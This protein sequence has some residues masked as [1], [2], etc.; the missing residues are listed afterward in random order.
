MNELI[1]GAASGLLVASVFVF[2]FV[3]IMFAVVRDP[4]LGFQQLARRL[5]PGTLVLSGVLMAYPSWAVIGAVAG[6]LYKIS[7]EQAPGSGLGSPNLMFT[8][9]IVIGA[10]A[11]AL[12]IAILLRQFL[13]G[14]LAV[15][16]SV[17]GLFGWF[18][19]HFAG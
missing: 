5:P 17:I 7:E 13:T 18:L 9:A 12:P 15:T 19:P 6:L 3:V 11:M 14:V 4:P 2:A 16:A 10:I 1:A 8:L